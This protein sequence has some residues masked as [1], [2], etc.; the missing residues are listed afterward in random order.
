MLDEASSDVKYVVHMRMDKRELLLPCVD[1]A[2][3]NTKLEVDMELHERD[4]HMDVLRDSHIEA[5]AVHLVNDAEMY[6]GQVELVAV[7]HKEVRNLNRP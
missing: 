6:F 7:H 3:H 2:E 5:G 1:L 4:A